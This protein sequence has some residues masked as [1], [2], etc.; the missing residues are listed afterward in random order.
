MNDLLGRL[1]FWGSLIGMNGVFLPMFL[2]GLA[3]MNRRLYDGGRTYQA[4]AGFDGSFRLQAWSAVFL[5]VVQIF[6]IVNFFWSLRKGAAVG[7]NPWQATTLEWATT[8]P[9]PAHNFAATP[10]VHRDAYGYS[11]PGAARD[12]LAAERTVIIPYTTE[13]RADT[14]VTNVTL[15]MW[16]FIASEVMLFGALF[17]AYALLRSAATDW[18]S[19]RQVLSLSLGAVEHRDPVDVDD[20]GVARAPCAGIEGQ[21]VSPAEFDPRGRVHR[22]QIR[23]N[24]STTTRPACCRT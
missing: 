14:G 10:V 12:F 23:S 8:S 15:G 22:L 11:V 3:G 19:G 2:Q 13:R 21:R 9:P 20:A 16:L 5:G 4:F 17:S 18:P 1:H 24:I 6:F 7:D